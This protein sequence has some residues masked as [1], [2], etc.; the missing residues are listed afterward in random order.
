[1]TIQGQTL[2]VASRGELSKQTSEIVS[3][4]APAG[5]QPNFPAEYSDLLDRKPAPLAEHY[6]IKCVKST[7]CLY[8]SRTD[9]A[10]ILNRQGRV[11]R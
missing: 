2:L 7:V 6:R 11:L 10:A 1:M 3:I 5:F 4:N 9:A 8:T